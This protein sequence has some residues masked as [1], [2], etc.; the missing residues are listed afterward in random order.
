M[1]QV[2][3]EC[4]ADVFGSDGSREGD[5]AALQANTKRILA[6]VEIKARRGASSPIQVLTTDF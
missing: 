1:V 6:V 4:L 2:T 3:G 5:D